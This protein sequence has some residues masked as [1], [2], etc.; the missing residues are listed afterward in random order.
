MNVFPNIL[1]KNQNL[2]KLGQG[3]VD[4]RAMIT[5]TLISSCHWK[6]LVPFY[7]RK[8]S[9]LQTTDHRQATDH[10]QPTYRQVLH[11]STNHRPPTH[12]QVHHR[13]TDHRPPTPEP[14]TGPPPTHRSPT[15]QPL[16]K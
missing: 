4:E 10:R 7:L 11:R 13:P 15:Y 2:K 16:T 3:F 1:H 9:V 8:K 6:T 14:L 5:T 12:Q